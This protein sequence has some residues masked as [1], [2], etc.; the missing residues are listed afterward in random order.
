[1]AKGS[2]KARVTAARLASV[3][4]VYQMRLNQQKASKVIEEFLAFRSGMEIDGDEMVPPDSEVLNEVISGV[5]RRMNEVE[6]LVAE[7]L[8]GRDVE[9]LLHAILICGAYE[10]LD[11]TNVDVPIIISDYLHVTSAFYDGKETNLVNA[12]LDGLGKDLRG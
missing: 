1:M 5:E 7:R 10:I 6:P 8:Q 3:Q 11:R 4:G 12:V 9:A 2:K